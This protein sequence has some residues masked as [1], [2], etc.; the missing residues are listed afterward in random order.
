MNR[1]TYKVGKNHIFCLEMGVKGHPVILF[2]HGIPACAEIWKETI[3]KVSKNGY[4]CLAPDLSGYGKTEIFDKE[5]YTLLGNAKLFNKWLALQNFNSIWLVGHDLGGA[6]AQLM[7][8]DNP[9]LFQKVT[10]SNVGTANTYPVTSIA[11]LVKISRF[12]LFYWLALMGKFNSDKL[13]SSMKLFFIRNHS[14]SKNEFERIFFDGKFHKRNAV[15]KFQNMLARLDNRYT[16]ENM[17]KLK[18]VKLPIHLLWA[19]DDKFQSW[20][21][22]GKILESTFDNVRVS[23][24]KNCGHYIQVDA[25]EEYIELL[26]S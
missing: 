14:F 3:E 7:L 10:L 11:K 5:Y 6:V 22:S 1:I 25:N 4:Y 20:Q 12:G 13:Y 9:S 23:K 19:L 8:T 17:E 18:S 15:A 16:K 2:L 26:L 21:V 24:I